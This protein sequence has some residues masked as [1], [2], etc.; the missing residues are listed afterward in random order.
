MII[1]IKATTMLSATEWKD[2]SISFDIEE[3]YFSPEHG[4]RKIVGMLEILGNKDERYKVLK[5]W[6]SVE[7]YRL[8]PAGS[9]PEVR[10][11]KTVNL[12]AQKTVTGNEI[13]VGNGNGDENTSS[14]SKKE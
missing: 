3:G 5:M 12:Q 7:G 8:V 13:S 2:E 14:P 6:A 11:Y 10:D 4:R 9:P 1:G